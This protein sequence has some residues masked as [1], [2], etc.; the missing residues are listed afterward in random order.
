MVNKLNIAFYSLVRFSFN[1]VKIH[2]FEMLGVSREDSVSTSNGRDVSQADGTRLR[3]G[4]LAGGFMDRGAGEFACLHCLASIIARFDFC[5]DSCN[6]IS[7][8]TH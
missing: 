4:I 6:S 3:V 1:C 7:T 8:Y 2:W 5:F